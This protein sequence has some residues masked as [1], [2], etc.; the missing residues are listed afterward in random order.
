MN[1]SAKPAADGS[2][3][4][5]FSSSG[6]LSLTSSDDGNRLLVCL[7]RNPGRSYPELEWQV[8]S[9]AGLDASTQSF[10]H[11]AMSSDGDLFHVVEIEETDVELTALDSALRRLID[12]YAGVM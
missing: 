6:T 4:F 12:L 9:S 1:L 7:S 8:F 2:Y 11:S 3:T 5:V 10:V